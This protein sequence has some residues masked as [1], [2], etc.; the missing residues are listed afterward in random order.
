M[1][2]H[3]LA[4]HLEAQ[5]RGT[6]TTLVHMSPRELGGLEALARAKGGS[7]TIN[8][9]TGLPEAGF[10]EDVLPIAAAGALMYFAPAAAPFIGEGLG[11]G[12]G[13]LGTGVG[14]GLLAGG[15]QAAT[16]L[17]G[18]GK[19]DMNSV[20]RTG[21][22]SGATAGALKGFDVMPSSNVKTD[23][24]AL[25]AA[26]AATTSVQP[27]MLGANPTAEQYA[28][29]DKYLGTNQ[30]PGVTDQTL[31]ANEANKLAAP[32][33]QSWWGSLTP[34]QK[35]FTGLGGV[36]A[37]SLLGQ[38]Q[39]PKITPMSTTTP[40]IRPY[41]YNQTRNPLWGQPGQAYF[42]QSYTA[43]TPYAA[44]QGGLMDANVAPADRATMGNQMFPMSQMDKTQYAT[45]SQMPTSAEVVASDYEPK[46]NAFT[47]EALRF[48]T[49][50]QTLNPD[51]KSVV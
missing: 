19:V 3:N 20:L 29:W 22:L 6:D 46:T 42:N 43:G 34:G 28:A 49:G 36:T 37:L 45:P 32:N 7:L 21:V 50:G 18:T 27:E 26:K 1:S 13:A 47:G 44:A 10:L 8:P 40:M 51:R 11:L 39:T 25:E 12:A 41:T 30:T 23:V 5:G 14:M 9:T 31:F 48:A 38:S 35:L 33:S 2:I 24:P 16:Q 17:L 4:K 15:A